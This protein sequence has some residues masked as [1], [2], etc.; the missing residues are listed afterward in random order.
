M[1]KS[2]GMAEAAKSK[3]VIGLSWEPK[4]PPLPSGTKKG[5]DKP[6]Q[7]LPESSSSSAAVYKSNTELIDGLFV[8]PNNPKKLNK[9]LR[10]QVKDTAGKNWFDMPAQTLTPELTK[11][12]QLLK[13]RSVID[14]KR[15]YKKGDSKSRTVPKYFQVGTVI[16]SA[17]DFFTG[18]LTK[19]ERKATLAD[20][21]L[22]DHTL[23]EYRKRKVREIEEQN[24]P[25]GVEK[26]K[27]KGRQ[28]W[29]RAKQRR[30]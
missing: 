2:E 17:S 12:L 7:T 30:H 22:S 9:L 14:P 15:H 23:G 16:E 1:L 4:L 18:R 21:L 13:L 28:S 26:W 6:P 24:R 5:S 27:I 8:P 10:K 19:K 11:D 3:P 20:E 29:K 25:G